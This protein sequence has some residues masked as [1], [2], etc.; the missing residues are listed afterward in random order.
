MLA[1]AGHENQDASDS[2]FQGA[3]KE[4]IQVQG[5]FGLQS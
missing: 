2:A 5:L 1:H 3:K 4:G